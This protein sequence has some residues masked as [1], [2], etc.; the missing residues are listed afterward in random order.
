MTVH[1]CPRLAMR[2][3]RVITLAVMSSAYHLKTNGSLC[4]KN[5]KWEGRG[6]E[7]WFHVVRGIGPIFHQGHTDQYKYEIRSTKHETNS[8]YECSKYR[9][10]T[11][12]PGRSIQ[13]GSDLCQKAGLSYVVFAS[14]LLTSEYSHAFWVV[15]FPSW[16]RALQVRL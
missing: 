10:E 12:N 3:D 1:S 5:T 13:K 16:C 15:V 7:V 4:K 2:C 14:N 6:E 11:W 9:S 8:K